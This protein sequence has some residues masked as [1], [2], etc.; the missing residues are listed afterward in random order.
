[1]YGEHVGE[2]YLI[3]QIPLKTLDTDDSTEVIN[4]VLFTTHEGIFKYSKD[5][6]G[7]IFKRPKNLT[8][9]EALSLWYFDK[10]NPL[11]DYP[12]LSAFIKDKF[13]MIHLPSFEIQQNT[14]IQ[15]T[16]QFLKDNIPEEIQNSG[17]AVAIKNAA[18]DFMQKQAENINKF[19]NNSSLVIAMKTLDSV[20]SSLTTEQCERAKAILKH[21]E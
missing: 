6:M 21:Y 8:Q 11:K 1:M 9:N 14:F 2:T 13:P 19:I 18:D 20:F 3:S 10:N 12:N 17:I 5:T 15:K 4:N 16:E 7:K